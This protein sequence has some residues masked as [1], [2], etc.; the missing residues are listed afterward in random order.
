MS[1]LE[2]SSE[3]YHR[4]HIVAGMVFMSS[5]FLTVYLVIFKLAPAFSWSMGTPSGTCQHYGMIDAIFAL[6]VLASFVSYVLMSMA[7]HRSNEKRF[8]ENARALCKEKVKK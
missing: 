8:E 7:M 1:R 6:N 4:L 5:L 2:L 3:G